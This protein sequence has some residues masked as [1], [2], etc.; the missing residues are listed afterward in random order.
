MTF[1]KAVCK[2]KKM[3]VQDLIFV[4]LIFSL[5]FGNELVFNFILRKNK[6][7][8]FTHYFQ[9]LDRMNQRIVLA[10]IVY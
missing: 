9:W 3:C 1:V 8:N 5:L 4:H 6:K 7:I 10:Q 2:T